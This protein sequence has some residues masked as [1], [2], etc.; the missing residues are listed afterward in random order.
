MAVRELADPLRNFGFLLKDV[1]RLYTRNFERHSVGL[2]LTLEQ[3]KVLGYLQGNEGISQMRL[4]YLADM[5]PMTLGR[6]L[7]RMQADGMVERRPDPGDRR[8][9]CLFLQARA[10]PLLDEIWRLSDRAR[11]EALAGLTGTDRSR[12]MKLMRHIQANLDKLL[13]GTADKGAAARRSRKLPAPAA[14]KSG[15]TALPPGKS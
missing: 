6:L 12:L 7:E 9:H 1:S 5:D 8:A 4:A 11:T 3:C 14:M 15:R 10:I 2:G 13:P